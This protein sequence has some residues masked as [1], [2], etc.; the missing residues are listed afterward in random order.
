M[1]IN[2]KIGLVLSGGGFKGI[3]QLGILHYI[4]ELKIKFNAVAG[5]S[6]G[7]LIGAFIAEGYTPYKVLEIG[8]KEKIFSYNQVSIRNGG[9][10]STSVIDHLIKKYIPHNS[11][12]HL[13]IP[14]FASTTNLNEG[15]EITFN[16]GDLS[17]AVAASCAFPMIFQPVLYNS[18]YLCDGGIMN[19]FPVEYIAYCCQYVIGINVNPI[20]K[21]E[22]KFNYK[23]MLKRILRIATSKISEHNKKL[24]TLYIEPENIAEYNMF[25]VSKI[26]ELF[27]LGYNSARHYRNELLRIKDNK[28]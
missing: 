8:K 6:A 14:F 27:E 3:A 15:K 25:N 7:A 9:V 21:I 1:I 18:D 4:H 17:Q 28:E 24:C 2:N 26:D 11:F 19:N 5:T 23:Q 12:E 20:E 10:F 13:K 16:S 22:G